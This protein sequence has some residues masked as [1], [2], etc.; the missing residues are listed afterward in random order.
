MARLLFSMFLS[1]K[2]EKTLTE[3]KNVAF[4]FAAEPKKIH[5][6][7]SH[8]LYFLSGMRIGLSFFFISILVTH[9]ACNV[10]SMRQHRSRV[11]THPSESMPHKVRP[12]D[13]SILPIIGGKYVK[14]SN[15]AAFIL[16]TRPVETVCDAMSS[17]NRNFITTNP[18]D[19]F[20]FFMPEVENKNSQLQAL[21]ECLASLRTFYIVD[22]LSHSDELG[23]ETP[24]HVRDRNL[25]KDTWTEAYRRMGHWR[26]TS[27]FR[28]ARSLGYEYALQV[29]DDSEFPTL[30]QTNIFEVMKN[31]NLKIG[32]RGSFPDAARVAVGLPELTRYFIVTEGIQP[33][34]LLLQHCKPPSID[35]LFSDVNGTGNGW[36]RTMFYGN[37]VVYSV[38]FMF[39]E[40]V[41]RFIKLVL[42][43]GGH[44]RF[45]WNEQATIGMVWQLFVREG[46]YKVFDFPYKHQDFQKK[47]KMLI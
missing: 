20:V 12:A 29:D 22:I 15:A 13:N 9:F 4:T 27:Q 38:D 46:E 40:M 19:V 45:R 24:A 6:S 28:F 37:F 32:G 26:L 3:K 41:Q 35:G 36:D 43:T 21:A 44:F 16:S 34:P 33:S 23:W 30:V 25:W 14:T 17:L 7:T 2:M 5:K 39:E 1:L 31:K 42:Q 11:D 47:K 10:D 18:A 8:K